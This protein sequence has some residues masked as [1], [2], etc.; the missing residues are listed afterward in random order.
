MTLTENHPEVRHT[1]SCHI[2]VTRQPLTAHGN[3]AIREYPSTKVGMLRKEGMIVL[4][5]L[6][7]H[8]CDVLQ[9]DIDI[10]GNVAKVRA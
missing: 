8:T 5:S 1:L 3:S 6:F 10:H 2:T 7:Q 4:S 9:Y